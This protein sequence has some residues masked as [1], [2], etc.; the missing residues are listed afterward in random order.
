M[1]RDAKAKLSARIG[2][3]SKNL[4]I[5]LRTQF[6]QFIELE[7]ASGILLLI[8]TLIALVW[9]NSAWKESYTE[10]LNTEVSIGFGH[11]VFATSLLHWINDG[12]MAVFFFVVGLE[13]KRELLVGEL[14]MPRQAMLPIV[15]AL[16]GMVVPAVLYATLNAGTEA[17]RGWGI[18]MATDIAFAVGILSILGTRVP[19]GLKVFLIALAI[20]DDLGAVIV[21][22]FFYTS[23]ISWAY[24]G[25]AAI[26]VGVLI[27]A[28]VRGVRSPM[29]YGVLG[30][31]L[32]FATLKSGVHATVAGVLLATTIPSRSKINQ[33]E[34]VEQGN[35]MLAQFTSEHRSSTA[36]LTSQQLSIIGSLESKAEDV[37]P[38]MQ[39]LEHA[40]HPWVSY[41]IMPVFALANAGATILDG[42]ALSLF[43][44]VSLGIIAG[45]LL[46]KQAGITLFSWA[47]VR[48][49]LAVLPSGVSWR[50]MYGAGLLGG[51]GFTMSLFIAGL[52]FG[53]GVSLNVAK[54]GIL[55]G[56]V[57]AGVSGYLVLR[58]VNSVHPTDL[59]EGRT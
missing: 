22:A 39:R 43:D 3:G 23:Q 2:Q 37:Q 12:L 38:P 46:G 47:A 29:V 48:M 50:H 13:I 20:V 10:L 19:A 6:D 32:W 33:P 40:L 5:S 45:L 56:S 9:A 53:D 7:A 17:A 52:A 28:N 54:V 41:F 4:L 18:P 8:C 49:K 21:I 42:M 34:F 14:A 24:L 35:R 58:S 44:R 26:V 16:G 55:C 30:M 27:L 31:I 57:L 15:G 25:F 36:Y 11:F 59:P 1:T 51:I